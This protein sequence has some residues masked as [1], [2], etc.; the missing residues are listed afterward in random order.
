MPG[1]LS[2]KVLLLGAK[3]GETQLKFRVSSSTSLDFIEQLWILL[4]IASTRIQ[5][6]ADGC[7]NRP[8]CSFRIRKIKGHGFTIFE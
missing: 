7:R 8:L 6:K 5:E 4:Q 3:T 1:E 2:E